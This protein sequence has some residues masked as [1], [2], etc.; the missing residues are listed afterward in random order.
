MIC[1]QCKTEY[2]AIRA[3]SKFCSAKCRVYYNRG[4]SVTDKSLSV[5]DSV[6]KPVTV[7]EE[8]P[9]KD[10]PIRNMEFCSKHK[11]TRKVSCGCK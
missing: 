5:T 4:V 1:I 10:R 9:L 8:Q 11:N 2:E 7:K 6:T 3:T